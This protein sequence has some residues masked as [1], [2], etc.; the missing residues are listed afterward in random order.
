MAAPVVIVGAG[1]AGIETAV[2]L[3]S[4]GFQDGIIIYGDEPC[5]PYQRPPLSKEFLKA[6]TD[7]DDIALRP[8]AYFDRHQ[9][10]LRCGVTVAEIDRAAHRVMLSDGTTQDYQHLVLATGTRN[11]RIAV[12]GAD[13]GR[14]HYL[15]TLAE[16]NAL[17]AHLT[18]C[19]SV[20]VIGAGFIGL[21][22]AAAARAHGASVTVVEATERPMGRAISQEMSHYFASLHRRHQVRLLLNTAVA[23]IVEND[24]AAATVVTASGDRIDAD[25]IVVGIGVIP[26]TEIASAAGLAVDNGI[27]VDARLSTADPHVSAIG[28]CAAYPHPSGLG[29]VRLES[30]QNAV[31]HA[32]C[33]AARLTGQPCAYDKVPWFW[34]EQFVAKLQM[35]GLLGDYDHTVVR[36]EPERD[37]F[38]VFCFR[39]DTLLAVESVNAA[40]DHMTA[41]KLLAARLTITPEQAADSTVDLKAA[42]EGASRAFAE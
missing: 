42:L 40:R 31:D 15:R 2:A 1:Q 35:A 24:C 12:P 4:K 17:T 14:V 26:N 29:L 6:S 34:T 28:D 27:V 37:S 21:E 19:A 25:L 9:I 10:E 30:V 39:G 16:A 22:V 5:A 8:A 13:S 7:S 33:V 20:V 36:G 32:R 41:R 18:S 38:S 11:R 3:R 23:E